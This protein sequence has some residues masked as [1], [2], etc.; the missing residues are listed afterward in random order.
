MKKALIGIIVGFLVGLAVVG[1]SFGLLF[2]YSKYQSHDGNHTD[3]GFQ[4][5]VVSEKDNTTEEIHTQTSE[6]E[7]IES[8]IIESEIIETTESE[9]SD[10]ED[11]EK[12][13]SNKNEDNTVTEPNYPYYIKVNRTTNCITV[14]AKDEKGDYTIPVKAIVCSVGR[15]GRTPTGVFQTKEK[16]VWKELYGN[17]YG[18]YSTRITG[19]VL[20]H[21]VPYYVTQKN[22]LITNYYNN[23]GNAASAGC[24]RLTCADAKWIYDNCPIGTSVEIMDSNEPDPL[25]KPSSLKIDVNSPYAG[26]DPTDPDPANPWKTV[27][28]DIVG[29]KDAV[30]ERNE[31]V[32]YISYVSCTDSWGIKLNVTINGNVDSRV[33]GSYSVSYSVVDSIGN[34]AS[35]TAVFLVKDTKAPIITQKETLIVK[36]TSVNVEQIIRAALSVTDNGEYF[37]VNDVE[38]DLSNLMVAM[39][40]KSY[41]SII[42][43]ATATDAFGNKT[44][45]FAIAISYEMEDTNPPMISINNM[46]L[47]TTEVN[48][49]GILMESDRQEMILSAAISSIKRGSHYRVLDDVSSEEEIVCDVTGMYVGI[50]TPGEYEI[51]LTITATDR[52]GKSSTANIVVKIIVMEGA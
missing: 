43:T 46:Q 12:T 16:Y 38:L 41:G 20:F 26:W 6:S 31:V 30:V 45:P 17:C 52:A 7:I 50:T 40:A 51:V 22:K 49:T 21:S 24:I 1:I 47:V 14:Y 35:K 25:G 27:T 42:C 2:L 34:T 10:T 29:V 32:D 18:Q 39:D 15:D 48:L 36:D 33:C 5:E 11:K 37:D 19:H 9:T 8:E 28:P 44:E 4:T 13:E 3:T 23:L